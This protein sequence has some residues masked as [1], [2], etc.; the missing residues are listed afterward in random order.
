M[1]TNS[2]SWEEQTRGFIAETKSELNAIETQLQS[3]LARKE[4]LASEL[5]AYEVA[6]QS[7][8]SK[9][10]KHESITNLINTLKA[11]PN[12]ATRL[13]AIARNAGG[14]IRV[15]DV[16]NML[17]V[18]GLV[19]TKTPGNAYKM[20]YSE[21]MELEV[22]GK[23]KRVAPATYRLTDGQVSLPNISS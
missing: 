11:M 21:L 10:G 6:L 14:T 22:D 9:S 15:S 1:V 17:F 12:L 19:K 23:F 3:L 13:A 7:R 2:Y 16:A 8:L 18:N 20:I 4:C 5:N